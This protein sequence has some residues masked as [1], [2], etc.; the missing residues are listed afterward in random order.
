M[1]TQKFFAVLADGQGKTS[2]SD[3]LVAMFRED[4]SSLPLVASDEST[5]ASLRKLA[6]EVAAN[7]PAQ[8]LYL[9]EFSS[10]RVLETFN[11]FASGT[12]PT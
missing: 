6:E 2:S 5:V 7:D 3:G 11:P 12:A 1:K 8:K 4:G 10:P 9:V